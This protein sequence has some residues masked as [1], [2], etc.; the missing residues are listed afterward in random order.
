MS[1]KDKELKEIEEGLHQIKGDVDGMMEKLKGFGS[2]TDFTHD[3]PPISGIKKA[4]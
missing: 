4:P 3:T 1:K 2:N